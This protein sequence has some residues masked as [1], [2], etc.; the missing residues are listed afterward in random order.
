[1]KKPRPTSQQ[2]YARY[3]KSDRWAKRKVEYYFRHDKVCWRCGSR[4]GIHLH[5][6]TYLRLGNELNE[7]LVP[8]CPPCHRRVHALHGAEPGYDLTDATIEA[9]GEHPGHKVDFEVVLVEPNGPDR[10]ASM[11]RARRSRG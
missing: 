11:R 5:H 8:L 7:D 2:R 9:I 6:H 3:I 4:D 1:M 10:R